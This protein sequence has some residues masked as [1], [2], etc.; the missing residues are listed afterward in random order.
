V[1]HL[2]ARSLCLLPEILVQSGPLP[3]KHPKDGD[4]ILPGQIYVAPPDQHLLIR[5]GG[6]VRLS[7]GPKENFT[8][9]AI[10]PLFRSAALEYSERVAGVILTGL[11][12]DGTAGLAAI[13]QAGGVAIVQDPRDAEEPSMPSSALRYVEIDYYVKVAEMPALLSDL[14]RTG[15]EAKSGS[16]KVMPED[17]E[18]EVGIAANEKTRPSEV[19]K[20]GAPS[21]FTCPECHGTLLKMRNGKPPRFR[22]HTGHAYTMAALEASMSE[23]IEASLW[24]AIRVLEEYA[25]LLTEAA[26]KAEDGEAAAK[27]AEA[28]HARLRARKVRD[29]LHNP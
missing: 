27:L 13:K 23:N 29:A 10:D 22:C 8:R 12:D 5:P 1:L 2:G 24:D 4:V 21:I 9:P 16:E 15:V 7:Y 20:L 11:L 19:A 6:H 26:D 18:F 17:A 14:A 3:A 28:E 25:M